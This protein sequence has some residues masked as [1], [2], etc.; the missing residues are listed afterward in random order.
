VLVW[1]IS[2]YKLFNFYG[3]ILKDTNTEKWV[4]YGNAY[5]RNY[6]WDIFGW[7]C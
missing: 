7:W 5:K 1:V 2:A 6:D 4:I 3:I